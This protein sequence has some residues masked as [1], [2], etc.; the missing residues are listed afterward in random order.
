[1]PR[2]SS[3]FRKV[4]LNERGLVG[5]PDMVKAFCTG[6][7]ESTKTGKHADCG[8]NDCPLYGAMPWGDGKPD[9]VW[10]V[11]DRHNTARRERVELV[12]KAGEVVSTLQ[13]SD[14]APVDSE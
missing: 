14:T 6:C 13:H 5:Y 11:M 10:L 2:K 1:M 7:E 4:R 8:Q 9:Y 3:G 12:N